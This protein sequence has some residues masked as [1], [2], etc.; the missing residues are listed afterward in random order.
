[1]QKAYTGS[2][3]VI[4]QYLVLAIELADGRH[5]LSS[6]SPRHARALNERVQRAGEVRRAAWYTTSDPWFADMPKVRSLR[7][8]RVSDEVFADKTARMKPIAL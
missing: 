2:E 4:G 1:M 7:G 3:R 5:F 6:V 8:R